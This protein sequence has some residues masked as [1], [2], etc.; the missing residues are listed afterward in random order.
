MADGERHI[1]GIERTEEIQRA[2]GERSA[3]LRERVLNKEH[4]EHNADQ[5]A[6]EARQEANREAKTIEDYKPAKEEAAP[7]DTADFSRNS[8]YKHTLKNI[9]KEMSAPSRAFSKLIHNKVID[10]TS[11]V[12]GTT[13]ARPNAILSGAICAFLLVLGLYTLAKYMGFALYGS[14][15]IAAFIIGWLLGILFDVVRST[16]RKRR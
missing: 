2:A 7:I 5:E 9:Q 15:T 3:E 10:K 11:D 4:G 16:F 1:G 8:S 13:V 12:I 6:A 14:E